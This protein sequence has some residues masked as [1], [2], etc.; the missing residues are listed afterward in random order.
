M[1]D[2]LS[3]YLP[4]L[5]GVAVGGIALYAV[6]KRK[7]ALLVKEGM[8]VYDSARSVES[9]VRN[10]TSDGGISKSDAEAIGQAVGKL[11]GEIVEFRDACRKVFSF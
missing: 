7:A 4:A 2:F 10:T 6:A 3:G 11:V 8:D 9:L 5:G 1:F